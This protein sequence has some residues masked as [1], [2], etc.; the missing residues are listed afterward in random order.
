M[1]IPLLRRVVGKVPKFSLTMII[2]VTK[3][4]FEKGW[5]WWKIYFYMKSK[6]PRV[7]RRNCG[8]PKCLGTP[9][10][11]T[12]RPA[13][14]KIPKFWESGTPNYWGGG[15]HYDWNWMIV[16]ILFKEV[17]FCILVFCNQ[18]AYMISNNLI[19]FWLIGKEKSKD[20]F[21]TWNFI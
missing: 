2:S 12:M 9:W 18:R 21:I 7:F 1:D 14:G 13:P 11:I 8:T 16:F 10:Y 20:L 17:H 19:I 3:R 6:S 5:K 15:T 4:N